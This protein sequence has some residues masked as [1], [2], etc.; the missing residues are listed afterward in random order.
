MVSLADGRKGAHL[1]SIIAITLR[2]SGAERGLYW[3]GHT[4]GPNTVGGERREVGVVCSVSP[5]A[6]TTS[7]V[8]CS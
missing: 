1:K 8:G 3:R 4:S 2:R 7:L 6:S 5:A